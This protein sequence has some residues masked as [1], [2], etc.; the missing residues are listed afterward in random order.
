[1]I[2]NIILV[3]MVVLVSTKSIRFNAYVEKDGREICVA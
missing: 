1:M 3:K 2:A